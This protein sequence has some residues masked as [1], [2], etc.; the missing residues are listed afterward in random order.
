MGFL[1]TLFGAGKANRDKSAVVLAINEFRAL[2]STD[3][4]IPFSEYDHLIE[5]YHTVHDDIGSVIRSGILDSYLKK[6]GLRNGDINQFN[7]Y[8]DNEN[9]LLKAHNDSYLGRKKAQ[10]KGYL[11][12]ILKQCDPNI[13]LDDEQRDVVLS[14]EDNTLVVAGAG[15][16]KTT[17]VSAKVK[18]LVDIKHIDPKDILVIS[19]TNKAVGELKERINKDL[20]IPCPICTFHSC[21][22]AIL[23][24]EDEKKKPV[25]EGFLFD[26][27]DRFFSEYV[28]ENESL[29]RNLVLFFGSYFNVPFT[30]KTVEEFCD[31]LRTAN[32]TA[33]KEDIEPNVKEI[34]EKDT[35]KRITILKENLN[36]V[37]EVT[38]ANYLFLNGIDYRY[39]DPY[40]HHIKGTSRPY[41]PDFHIFQDGKNSYLEH[42]G[43]VNDRGENPNRP[44]E[45]I[46]KYRNSIKTKVS[47]HKSHNTDLIYTFGKY[48]DGKSISE[49]LGESLLK[50]GYQLRPIDQKT[51]V[52][53]IV[54]GNDNKYYSKLLALLTRFISNFKINN[55]SDNK[56][57]E[58]M[59]QTKNERTKLFLKIAK[60]AF[61][62]YKNDLLS[63]GYIDFSDMINNSVRLISEAR[64][65]KEYLSFKYI[66][67]DEYQDISYQ[68]FD[69]A[70][71]LSTICKAKFVAVGDDWQSI[72]AFSG[73]D[74]TLFTEFTRKMGKGII[75]PITRTYR[76]SQ[77]LIDIAGTFVQK[78]EKQ[79]RKELVSNKH[80]TDPIVIMSYDSDLDSIK[81][82]SSMGV[83]QQKAVVVE[84][85][86]DSIYERRKLNTKD[87]ASIL[88]IGRFNF[89]APKLCASPL[90]DYDESK[91]QLIW[92]KHPDILI[93]FLTAHSS[94]GLTYDEVVLINAIDDRFGFPSQIEDDPILSLVVKNDTDY[95][96]AEE[97]RLFYVALTRTRD[98]VFIVSPEKHPSKFV[99]ELMNDYKDIKVFG[100]FAPQKLK[101]TEYTCPICGFPLRKRYKKGMGFEMYC[102]TN[103][104]EI[105]GFLTN[106]PKGGKL[107]IQ[108]CPDCIDGYLVVKP[109]VI[110]ETGKKG[111]VL[112]CTNYKPDGTGCRYSISKKEFEPIEW[113]EA[114]SKEPM[115]TEEMQLNREHFQTG[116]L[117]YGEDEEITNPNAN[118]STVVEEQEEVFKVDKDDDVEVAVLKTVAMTGWH[119]GKT[120][121]I[122]VLLG[123]NIKTVT[124]RGLDNS[125]MFGALSARKITK[126]ALSDCIDAMLSADEPTI[127][128]QG[129]YN[130]I[131]ITN[132][133]KKVLGSIPQVK[134]THQESVQSTKECESET[135]CEDLDNRNVSLNDLDDLIL[136]LIASDGWNYGDTTA[137]NIL[138][139]NESKHV[140]EKGLTT[141]PFFN[142][143]KN[144]SINVRKT[145][146]EDSLKKLTEGEETYACYVTFYKLLKLTNSGKRYLEEKYGYT[147]WFSKKTGKHNGF[148]DKLNE[149]EK[150]LIRRF[151]KFLKKDSK[152]ISLSYFGARMCIAIN[153]LNLFVISKKTRGPLMFETQQNGLDISLEFKEKN[154][155]EIAVLIRSVLMSEAVNAEMDDSKE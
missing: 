12:T 53:K 116:N 150:A 75:L 57:D 62:F 32:F 122:S 121:L 67:V 129:L 112:G 46:E 141:H 51:L 22:M 86:L 134:E 96:F 84:S 130:I 39:E 54:N 8:F 78:N 101:R 81:E 98:R 145:E 14:E 61:F 35:H 65:K 6:N 137:W 88:F 128:V 17:T 104:Q 70:K 144:N 139:G 4:Y 29:M 15:A 90:F 131:R 66:I 43:L 63:N 100:N 155:P 28:L 48:S 107:S 58:W 27:M 16:G 99:I 38:I 7:D 23:K 30:G 143:F 147:K 125:A 47:L 106:N 123:K 138:R 52:E 73:S 154:I 148:L 82:Y 87:K 2:L 111:F 44:E 80:L 72:Y 153:G 136:K 9:I 10:Y 59:I 56:F 110:Q 68:R 26:S 41:L 50:H 92:L 108:K 105:C 151:I 33:L 49:H 3:E 97:R 118:S 24:H 103:E 146:F 127:C 140:L 74:V 21:G 19:F 36:S 124:E 37:Q 71:E 20:Q 91:H 18:Y 89:D 149:E 83:T 109:Y 1:D 5:K 135:A 42:F 11:D 115:K 142:Y 102:C 126:I 133:G 77:E 45:E 132:K 76:N 85:I 93:D 94:K 119:Y 117:S 120:V 79:L 40:P 55:Y 95:E 31:Y 13:Q 113:D 34:I 64:K 152:T 114:A 69:L 25:T 60:E